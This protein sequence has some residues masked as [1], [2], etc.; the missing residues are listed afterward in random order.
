[1]FNL[2]SAAKGK[3]DDP[4]LQE[5]AIRFYSKLPRNAQAER[6]QI[7]VDWFHEF[8]LAQVIDRGVTSFLKCLFRTLPPQ[9][10]SNLQNLICKNLV[11]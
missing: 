5:W 3:L 6:S 10:F 8:F 1:M 4:I 7:E 11:T 2:I 9:H